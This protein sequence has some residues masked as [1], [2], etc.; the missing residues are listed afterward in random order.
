[1]RLACTDVMVPGKSITEKAT[2]LKKWGYEGISIFVNETSLND[3]LVDEMLALKEKTGVTPCEFVLMSDLYGHLMD[4]DNSVRKKAL[5]LYEKSIE[6]AGKF[7]GVTEMEYEYRA[8]DPLPLFDPYQ[9]MPSNDREYFIEIL[10]EL[11]EKAEQ[12]GAMILVEPCN[13]YETR[14]LTRITDILPFL[15]E[16]KSD[17]NGI[18]ADFFHMSIEESDIPQSI[19]TAGTSVKHVHLGDSNRLMPGRGHTDFK[20]AFKAL[21][22]NGYSGFMSLECGLGGAADVELPKCADYLKRLIR[23]S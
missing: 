3:D 15:A 8:Q 13:R 4:T 17:N 2:K 1:M 11:T 20:S 16:V 7:G 5:K 14:Y 12:H 21:K 10:K 18:L 22:R 6:I 19:T 23:T 9:N